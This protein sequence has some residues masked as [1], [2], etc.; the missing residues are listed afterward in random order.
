VTKRLPLPP[1]HVWVHDVR[2]NPHAHLDCPWMSDA[3]P[4]RSAPMTVATRE[5]GFQ[6][7][8]CTTE[9]RVYDTD[10]GWR[11]HLRFTREGEARSWQTGDVFREASAETIV[12]RFREFGWPA[13]EAFLRSILP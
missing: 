5:D 10:E 6:G 4:D 13:L 9:L 3:R 1:F 11:G 2:E 12:E 8:R 7:R